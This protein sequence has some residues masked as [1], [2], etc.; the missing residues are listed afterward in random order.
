MLRKI[1]TTRM[2]AGPISDMVDGELVL[3][4]IVDDQTGIL[5][6]GETPLVG[7]YSGSGDAYFPFTQ[8]V[9]SSEWFIQHNLGK[10]PSVTVKDSSGHQVFGDVNHLDANSLVVSFSAPFAGDAYLN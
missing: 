10:F 8:T 7:K 9:A 2:G 3:S 4:L 6:C 5:H 1:L